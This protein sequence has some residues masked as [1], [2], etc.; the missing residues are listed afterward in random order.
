VKG[1]LSNVFGKEEIPVDD[2][3]QDIIQAIDDLEK[4]DEETALR[5]AGEKAKVLS[6]DAPK[7]KPLVESE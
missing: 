6:E 5:M 3:S 1:K 4:V 7:K 2:E